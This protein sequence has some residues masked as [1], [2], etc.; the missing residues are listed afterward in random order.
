MVSLPS[1]ATHDEAVTGFGIFQVCTTLPLE[2]LHA[3]RLVNSA[4]FPGRSYLTV[5]HVTRGWWHTFGVL[6]RVIWAS[7][8]LQGACQLMQICQL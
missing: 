5:I 3:T 7:V 1:S 6:K 2:L 8:I 4:G